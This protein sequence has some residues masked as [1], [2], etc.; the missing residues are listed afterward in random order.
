MKPKERSKPTLLFRCTRDI[1]LSLLAKWQ[2]EKVGQHFLDAE[3]AGDTL[4]EPLRAGDASSEAI[5]LM[6]MSGYTIKYP[7][8]L[9]TLCFEDQKGETGED[10]T[11][12]YAIS[13]SDTDFERC[14][15][16]TDNTIRAIW[17]LPEAE[18]LAKGQQD[19][20]LLLQNAQR[21]V[22]ARLRGFIELLRQ[23]NWAEKSKN[24]KEEELITLHQRLLAEE[25]Q[26]GG[27][28]V[29]HIGRELE[30][31]GV[32]THRV[33]ADEETQLGFEVAE[34]V[35]KLV[36]ELPPESPYLS[37][38]PITFE[39]FDRK[40]RIRGLSAVFTVGTVWGAD[41]KGV[42]V[43]PERTIGILQQLGIPFHVAPLS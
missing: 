9:C 16:V 5:G 4:D 7:L 10:R 13:L 28:E 21:R 25:S 33:F 14:A 19:R 22:L 12:N 15:H 23:P 11:F 17:K 32:E 40:D 27:R 31:Q 39:G 29:I 34:A 20:G 35:S 38:Q 3:A 37:T 41:K 6:A 26:S 2:V 42:L 18:Y 43:V 30:P 8:N 1:D 36:A 24:E